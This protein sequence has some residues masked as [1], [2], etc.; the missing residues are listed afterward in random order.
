MFSTKYFSTGVPG[1]TIHVTIFV[2]R[3]NR[4][5]LRYFQLTL[6]FTRIHYLNVKSQQRREKERF[7]AG[8]TIRFCLS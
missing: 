7:R 1:I 5:F 4:F 8:Q 2:G 3:F 6:N